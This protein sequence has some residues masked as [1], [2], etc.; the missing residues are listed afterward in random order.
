MPFTDASLPYLRKFVEM[1]HQ[2][3]LKVCLYYTL[4]ELSVHTPEFW[5]MASLRGEIFFPGP[6]KEARPVTAPMGPHP[7]FQQNCNFPYLSAWAE[8]IKEGPYAGVLDLAL[9]TTP[10]A[11]RLENYF[12][13]GLRYLLERCPIDG[14]YLDD[15]S[16]T[17]EGFQRLIR[18]FRAVRGCDP[19]LTLHSWNS[20]NDTRLFYGNSS[21]VLRDMA[22]YPFLTSLWLGESF[23]YEAASPEYYLSEISGLPFG[24][25]SEMLSGGGNPWRG[26]LFGMTG[27]YGWLA[28][29]RPLWEL[30]DFMD[31]PSCRMITFC[32]R[33]PAVQCSV[34]QIKATLYVHPDGQRALLVAASWSNREEHV[35]FVF[36]RQQL[37]ERLR[38]FRSFRAPEVRSLQSSGSYPA[39]SAITI[40]PGRGAFLLLET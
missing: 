21:P 37:P 31:L 6:G 1:V 39:S 38:F 16:L 12:L 32:D 7:Y 17:R 35:Q 19:I 10:D 15:T 11:R 33:T 18:V 25:M 36:D 20:F 28:D 9:E 8:T 40:Q 3:K 34:P 23:D 27:R 29:P 24:L 30:F 5:A 4:R 22:F 26:M 14:L 2:E 13:E